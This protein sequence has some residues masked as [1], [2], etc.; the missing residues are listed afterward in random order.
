MKNSLK[1]LLA[2]C[3][4][5]GCETTEDSWE[6]VYPETDDGT[7]GSM[8]LPPPVS[9]SSGTSHAS[10]P[11]EFERCPKETYV[12]EIDGKMHVFEIRV[13]CDPMQDVYKGCPAPD[14]QGM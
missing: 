14:A 11:D 3:L 6:V 4:V 10:E 2:S 9:T 12:I 1:L 8:Q 7:G 13:F 5:L